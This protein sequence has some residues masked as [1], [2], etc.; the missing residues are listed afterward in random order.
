MISS[1]GN[2]GDR[3]EW[4]LF[5]KKKLDRIYRIFW[6]FLLHF[7]FPEET[8]NMQSPSAKEECTKTNSEKQL[9]TADQF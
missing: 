7:R 9:I 4:M 8:E 1:S 6:I 5:L 3:E 2:I